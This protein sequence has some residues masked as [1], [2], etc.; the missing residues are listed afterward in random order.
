MLLVIISWKMLSR[1][2]KGLGVS[3]TPQLLGDEHAGDLI[4]AC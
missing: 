2:T 4:S 1:Q 3:S